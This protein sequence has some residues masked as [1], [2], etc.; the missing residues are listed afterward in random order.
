MLC[1]SCNRL[2]VSPEANTPCAVPVE[3][4]PQPQKLCSHLAIPTV[5]GSCLFN[6]G[7]GLGMLQC[8]P[9]FYVTCSQGP[10]EMLQTGLRG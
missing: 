7:F 3:R 6:R 2:E 9:L 8:F 5:F 10:V 1:G 4:Q